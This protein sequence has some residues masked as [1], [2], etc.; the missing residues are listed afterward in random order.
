MGINYPF[1]CSTWVVLP[2][3]DKHA[4]RVDCQSSIIILA[5]PW[6][7]N[8]LPPKQVIS[9]RIAPCL[10]GLPGPDRCDSLECSANRHC[11]G[12]NVSF[13]SQVSA[14]WEFVC[15]RDV[16]RR[17]VGAL[18]QDRE[19][20]LCQVV[21]TRGSTPQKAGSMMVI[22]PDGGQVGTLGGGCVENEVKLKAIRS[23]AVSSAAVHSFVLDHDYAWAD[24]LIC[25]GKMVIVTQ[26]VRGPEPLAISA[27]STG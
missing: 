20:I 19:L 4:N 3:I 23:S 12:P 16:V 13:V 11:A 25:G 26:P 1:G 8:R 24:G 2:T 9:Q 10:G 17:M 14:S 6:D 21:E 7:C 15:M 5:R 18:E 27:R 22:D